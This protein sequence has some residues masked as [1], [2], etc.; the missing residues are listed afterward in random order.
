MTDNEAAQGPLMLQ[1]DHGNVAFRNIS[2]KRYFHQKLDLSALKYQFFETEMS[3]ALPN[4]DSL[5]YQ[6]EGTTDSF[7]IE[8]IATRED[9]FGI[10]FLGTINAPKNGDYVFHTISDDGSKLYIDDQLV[11]DNDFN[12]GMERKSGLL[13]LGKGSHDLKVDYYNNRWGKGL[14]VMYEGP[15]IIYQPLNSRAPKT[16]NEDRQELLVEIGE[17]PEMVRG[18]VNYA[19]EVRTHVISAGNPGGVHYSLDLRTGVLLKCWRGAFADVSNM[20]VNRGHSQLVIP[21]AVAVE[22]S[23]VPILAMLPSVSEP[24]TPNMPQ[25]KSEGYL[26]DDAGRPEFHYTLGKARAVESYSVSDNQERLIRDIDIEPNGEKDLFTR[27]AVASYIDYLSNGMYNIGGRYYLKLTDSNKEPV[28]R[29]SDG[30]QEL[31]IQLDGPTHIKY[32]L[33]W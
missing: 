9:F 11:V 1:G 3:A 14:I 21:Q 23:D 13:T 20:W 2:Y 25:L 30:R 16:N 12:H 4:F 18:F 27:L 26:L 5:D 33:T 31:S 24:N 19:G 28:I 29:E 8:S 6:S 15:E 10:R 32:S 17:T 22:L 7:N